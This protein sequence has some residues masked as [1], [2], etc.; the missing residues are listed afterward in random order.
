MSE[1]W[2]GELEAFEVIAQDADTRNLFLHMATMSASGR[3]LPLL[4][5]LREDGEVDAETA[6]ALTELASDPAFLYAV[7]DYVQRTMR[8]H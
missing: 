3:L 5:Q 8:F 1:P 6:G 4:E 2:T 7:E